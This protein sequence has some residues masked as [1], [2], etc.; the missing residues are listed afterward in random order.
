[1]TQLLVTAA[2]TMLKSMTV[3]RTAP[4][5]SLCYTIHCVTLKDSI[6]VGCDCLNSV[7]YNFFG[8]NFSPIDYSGGCG[9]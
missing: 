4:L 6:L 9:A 8:G 5:Q 2:V 3:S 1:M 7:I